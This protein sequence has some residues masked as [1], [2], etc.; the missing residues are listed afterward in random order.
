MNFMVVSGYVQILNYI[1]VGFLKFHTSNCY[2]EL[3]T[4]AQIMELTDCLSGFLMNFFSLLIT[5]NSS[6]ALPMMKMEHSILAEK[7]MQSIDI[8]SLKTSRTL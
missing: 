4:Q 5:T 1:S 8:I 2:T 3:H 6:S 7:K